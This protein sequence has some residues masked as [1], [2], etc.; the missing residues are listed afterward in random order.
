M[1]VFQELVTKKIAQ[2]VVLLVEGEDG[3]V[4]STFQPVRQQARSR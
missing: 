2:G 4:W 3:C 1:A